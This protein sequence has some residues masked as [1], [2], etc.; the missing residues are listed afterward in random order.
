MEAATMQV[1]ALA[2]FELSQESEVSLSAAATT[3]P[4]PRRADVPVIGTSSPG[5]SSPISTVATTWSPH[6]LTSTMP[7]WSPRSISAPAPPCSPVSKTQLTPPSQSTTETDVPGNW[8]EWRLKLA[9]GNT[10]GRMVNTIWG[11]WEF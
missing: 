7:P 1:E 8:C 2:A 3:T 11:T 5:C 6:S 4:P 10:V 9:H